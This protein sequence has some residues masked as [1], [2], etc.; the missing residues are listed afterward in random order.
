LDTITS[1]KLTLLFIFAIVI[2]STLLSV[3]SLVAI[4]H[5]RDLHRAQLVQRY[6][7]G[8]VEVALALER[9]LLGPQAEIERAL[10]AISSGAAPADGRPPALA[11]LADAVGALAG[12]GRVFRAAVVVGPGGALLA[13]GPGPV[14]SQSAEPPGDG[15]AGLA[16]FAS[17]PA[18]DPGGRRPLHPA[19]V[20]EIL[21][22]AEE[23]E[24]R[25]HDDRAA[26]RAYD[27]IARRHADDDQ[28]RLETLVARARIL[29]RLGGPREAVYD[30]LDEIV[31][32]HPL[33][34]DRDGGLPSLAAR[35]EIAA[36]FERAGDPDA[37]V[38][39]LEDLVR[40][41][42]RYEPDLG[43][44][45]ASFYRDRALER[46]RKIGPDAAERALAAG[47]AAR[48]DREA[49]R[50]FAAALGGAP[51][52]ARLRG[53][54]DRAAS[55]KE[56][57]VSRYLIDRAG[58]ARLVVFFAPIP[59]PGGGALGIAAFEVDLDGLRARELEPLVASEAAHDEGFF[60]LVDRG[61]PVAAAPGEAEEVARRTLRPPLDHLEV[62]ALRRDP[63][64]LDPL[65]R[66]RDRIY[67]WA[68]A[69][70][71]VGL[72]IGA[73]ITTR[74]VRKEM[75]ASHL[76]SD[77]VTTVTHELKTPLTSI[78]M[79]AETLLMGRV[80][81]E[82]EKKECLEIIAKETDRLTRLIDR[83]LTFSKIEARKKRFDLKLADP[84][85]LVEETADLFR[86][87]MRGGK[88]PLAL[89]VTAVQDLPKVLV[90]RASMQ[91]VLLNLLSNA[92]KY[93]GEQ[94]RI[95][96]TLT[97]RRRW[98]LVEVRDRGIG[99]PWREQRK[100]FR[101][102]YRANDVLTRDVEGS[103]IGLTLARSIVQA[104]RGDITVRSK[105]G[106]GST[107]TVW[108]PR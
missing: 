50:A 20:D 10:A 54:A 8:A 57:P 35:L 19:E 68:I 90:D 55:G 94:P 36:I 77:F 73:L 26:L 97:K 18:R 85:A 51:L 72:S 84:L 9:R 38:R 27:E 46:L 33:A 53:L 89:E 64:A 56:L 98:V 42:G 62:V 14:P 59:R 2:P 79:F 3:V 39:T 74:A 44:G 83:V 66:L 7:E 5:E 100:I 65:G 49:A 58:D 107:F 76:K 67:S 86:T 70:A 24:Y 92:Y 28:V 43:A 32:R 88:K 63:L 99:I 48:K 52:L 104:H 4:S 87:Q 102:F 101:K 60:R 61:A 12:A 69:L 23:L 31:R 16:A 25:L 75:K 34:R 78:G 6:R 96:V 81:D 106:E 30:A 22:P 15:Q 108:L 103:G 95:Q 41:A 91:E 71:L 29:A 93:G 105:V 37:E 82:A 40:F 13:G 47:L 45:A 1:Y 80:S 11:D 21:R 17:L